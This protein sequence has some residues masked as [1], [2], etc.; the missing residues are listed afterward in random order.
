MRRNALHG[1][2][3]VSAHSLGSSRR[4]R[5]RMNV[6][7]GIHQLEHGFVNSYLVADGTDLTLID[8]GLPTTWPHLLTAL[9]HFDRTVDDI[10]AVVLTHAHFDH[11]GTARRLQKHGTPIWLHPDD[12]YIAEYPYRYAHEN[13]RLRYPM[14]YPAARPILASMTRAGALWVRGITGTRNLPPSGVID[15]PGQPRVVFSPGHTAG[16]IALHL[17]DRDALL[18]GDALVTLDPYTGTTGPQIV[19]GAATA[20][21]RAACA[22]LEALALTDARIILPG[23]GEPWTAGIRSAVDLALGVGAT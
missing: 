16:H 17:P 22:S 15:V 7:P 18:T 6:A 4:P 8:T 20:D 3:P 5:F 12:R 13:N 1:A 2:E 9:N 23:H 11:L 10:H 14:T 19:A 21:S